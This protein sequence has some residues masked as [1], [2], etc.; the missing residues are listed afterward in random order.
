MIGFFDNV[1]WAFS[2]GL[3]QKVLNT[4]RTAGVAEGQE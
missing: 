3:E 1:L 4:G 2:P